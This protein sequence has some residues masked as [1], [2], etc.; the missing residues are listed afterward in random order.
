MAV[1]T[2]IRL[3]QE[4]GNLIE[5]DAQTMVLTT[6]RKVGGSALP[7]TG[8][9]RFGLDLN[10]NKA[11]IN[12]QGIITDDQIPTSARGATATI[13]FGLVGGEGIKKWAK[14]FNFDELMRNDNNARIVL[15]DSQG[16]THDINMQRGGD[17]Q[18]TDYSSNGLTV[19]GNSNHPGILLRATNISEDANDDYAVDAEKMATAVK[20]Y[21]DNHLSA[22][23]TCDIIDDDYVGEGGTLATGQ[24]VT[25]QITQ[26]V[27]DSNPSAGDNNNYPKIADDGGRGDDPNIIPFGGSRLKSTKSAGDKVQDIYGILNNS[28]TSLGRSVGSSLALVGGLIVGAGVIAGTGGAGTPAG[29]AIA[30]AGISGYG[31]G[32]GTTGLLRNVNAKKDYIVGIQ[33]PY[34]STLKA[35]DG[36]TYTARNF[37]MSTGLKE[38]LEK[39]SH[40]SE[41]A[42]VEYENKSNT[43]TGIKG[44]VQK[45]DITYNAGEA[46]YEFNMIFAP[47]DRLM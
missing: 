27:L 40:F 17:G 30:G 24:P 35:T 21:I 13:N 1:G 34:N 31:V 38:G 28:A 26:K 43:Y 6:S 29:L 5:L 4:N 12:V 45:M 19:G 18:N 32:A 37:F 14:N 10:V 23:F 46:I 36:E 20:T 2:P 47:I 25:V 44:A 9:T 42:G 7:A 8:S 22:K 16:T 3:V 41:P 33:I 11:M 15:I 39:G